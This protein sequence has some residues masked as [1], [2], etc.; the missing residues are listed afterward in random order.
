MLV[1]KSISPDSSLNMLVTIFVITP[2]FFTLV[3]GLIKMGV[4]NCSVAMSISLSVPVGIP[5][6]LKVIPLRSNTVKLV[7]STKL[8]VVCSSKLGLN[9]I[10]TCSKICNF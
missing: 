3:G 4:V 2:N 9:N 8:S 7:Q 5:L 10:K 1:P 6:E